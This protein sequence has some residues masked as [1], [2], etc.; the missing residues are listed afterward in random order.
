M[1]NKIHRLQVRALDE[2]REKSLRKVWNT[3]QIRAGTGVG[4]QVLELLVP[5]VAP[6]STH[7]G[8]GRVGRRINPGGGVPPQLPSL[9]QHARPA[10][11][12]TQRLGLRPAPEPRLRFPGQVPGSARPA[13]LQDAGPA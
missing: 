4:S 13:G 5:G 1:E 12:P 2:K 7:F 9:H 3:T 8:D 6:V 10:F 11:A